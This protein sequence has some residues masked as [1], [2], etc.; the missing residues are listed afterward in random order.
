MTPMKPQSQGRDANLAGTLSL[1][2]LARRWNT[3]RKALRH[4]LGR[5]EL[6]FVQIRGKFRVPLEEIERHER[7][8]EKDSE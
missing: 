6:G 4:M 5:Q 8:R 1:R 2:R 7:E 3:S